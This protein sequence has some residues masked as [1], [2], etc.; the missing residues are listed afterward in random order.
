[1]PVVLPEG[2]P[3]YRI[4]LFLSVDLVG[5]TAFKAKHANERADGAPYAKWLHITKSFYREFPDEVIKAYDSFA[6]QHRTCVELIRELRPQVWKTVGDEIIFC[7]GLKNLEH[8]ALCMTAFTAALEK[9]GKDLQAKE[10]ELD[11]KGSAWIASFPAPNSTI[12]S[13]VRINTADQPTFVGDTL[14]E[15][16]ERKADNNPGGYDFLGKSIDTGFRI[17]RFAHA[18]QLALSI[19]LAY[20]LALIKHIGLVHFNFLFK[21]REPLKGV[22]NGAPYPVV[23]IETEKSAK[24]KELASFERNVTGE[25]FV[26][27]VTLSSYIHAFMKIHKMEIPI[28]SLSDEVDQ[29]QEDVLPECYLS[30]REAFGDGL[31]GSTL[32]QKGLAEAEEAAEGDRPSDETNAAT[33][34]RFAVEKIQGYSIKIGKPQY[35]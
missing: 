6:P 8:L 24:Q 1:M 28:L 10:P 27:A 3:A 32:Q 9:Y 2:C 21:G 18:D 11:L 35:R 30:F 7:V 12:I 20:L 29:P 33:L 15:N 13:A 14:D 22:I 19:D 25:Q 16:E 5:S 26:D 31:I 34:E 17:S 23:V 4:R